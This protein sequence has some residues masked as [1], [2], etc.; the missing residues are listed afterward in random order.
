MAPFS[1]IS[2]SHCKHPLA[3]HFRPRRRPR[4]S[5]PSPHLVEY[6][7][8]QPQS[9]VHTV[10]HLHGSI[11]FRSRK[12]QHPLM[13]RSRWR[14]LPRLDSGPQRF[15]WQ[16]CRFIPTFFPRERFCSGG[17]AILQAPRIFLRSTSMQPMR[18]SGIQPILAA[19]AKPT[20]NQPTDSQGNSINL[21]CSGH[22]FLADGRLLVTGGHIFDSQGL[23]T[24]TFYDPF[25]DQWSAGP[26]HEQRSLVSYGRHASRRTGVRMFRQFP[27]RRPCNHPNNPNT[28]QQ[29]FAGSGERDL[30]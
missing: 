27:H 26:D 19:P 22:T 9:G 20:G 14:T 11:H 12:R 21:F 5:T 16:T 25:A 7:G 18:S 13:R 15:P 17:G 4:A 30:E 6:A 29:Y 28:H 23:N 2:H 24:S 1:H 8:G 10:R 3:P